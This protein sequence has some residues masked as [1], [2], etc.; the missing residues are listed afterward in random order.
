MSRE[1]DDLILELRNPKYQ[2]V[3]SNFIEEITEKSPPPPLTNASIKYSAFYLFSFKPEYTTQ[4]L[5]KLFE[6]GL[7]TNPE[8]NGWRI[9]EDTIDEIITT[10]H[11]EYPSEMVLDSKRKYNDIIIDRKSNECI[12]P[13]CFTTDFYPK[14]ILA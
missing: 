8:T 5:N 7:I 1:R 11:Q 14:N 10:L 12:R 13:L 9:E 4:L 2:H 6:T 3:V